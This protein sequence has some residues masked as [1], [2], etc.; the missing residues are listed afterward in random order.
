MYVLSMLLLNITALMIYDLYGRFGPFHVASVISLATIGAGFRSRVSPAAT[1][2][3]DPPTCEFHVLVVC[4][5][6]GSV[7]VR[8]RR[9]DPWSRIRL[10]RNR[11]D[12]DRRGW[13]GGS[14]SYARSTNS[15]SVHHGGLTGAA[16][17]CALQ[18]TK[19]DSTG[20][21]AA[22]RVSANPLGR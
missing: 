10:C 9:S 20:C 6:L 15:G 16:P 19:A 2:G 13:R 14:Y 3:V 1:G 21:C 22:P 17:V 11:R 7:R 5:S 4:G 8:S 18:E 12:C